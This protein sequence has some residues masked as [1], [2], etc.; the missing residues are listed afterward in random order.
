MIG[1][2]ALFPPRPRRHR[3]PFANTKYE[4]AKQSSRDMVA[5]VI[6]KHFDAP[7]V[8]VMPHYDALCAKT[9]Q[10]AIPKATF[11]GADRS[12]TVA[13]KTSSLVQMQQ[14]TVAQYIKDNI[15]YIEFDAAFLDYTTHYA[16]I[17]D[18]AKSFITLLKPMAV[19]A[20]TGQRSTLNDIELMHD[21][22]QTVGV[23]VS[24]EASMEYS[25]THMML[26]GVFL[27][28]RKASGMVT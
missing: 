28:T 17:Q 15:G 18:D 13:E 12:A 10:A 8:F 4:D 27:I 7:V 14:K 16:R 5:N 3:P 9:I 22:L 19:L 21:C 6:A 2:K 25:T 24:L 11:A 1:R 26:C 23:S 20:I